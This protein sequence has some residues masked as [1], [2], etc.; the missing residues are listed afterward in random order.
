MSLY[1]T[2]RSCGKPSTDAQYRES[3]LT[4]LC[5]TC[6]VDYMASVRAALAALDTED[7]DNLFHLSPAALAA[8]E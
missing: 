4:V 8:M 5:A 3:A 6:H 1:R 7:D 2:C